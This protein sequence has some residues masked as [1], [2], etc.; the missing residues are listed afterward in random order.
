MNV[1]ADRS[2]TAPVIRI[3]HP[4][5]VILVDSLKQGWYRVVS[6]LQGLGYVDRRYLD[7]SPPVAS[8]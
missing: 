1:R 4:G 5:E 3:L 2:S 8:P 7:T 6:D